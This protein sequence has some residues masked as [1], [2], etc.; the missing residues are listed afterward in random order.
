MQSKL[1]ELTEKIY[2]EGIAKGNSEAEKIIIDAL[3]GDPQSQSGQIL[4]DSINDYFGRVDYIIKLELLYS[5][6]KLFL[7]IGDK[8]SW[9]KKQSEILKGHKFITSTAKLLRTNSSD[10]QIE[11]L[12]DYISKL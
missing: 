11:V 8:I 3:S 12:E 5:E 10:K 2:Q 1:Q 7:G 9:F 6:Q 4:Y